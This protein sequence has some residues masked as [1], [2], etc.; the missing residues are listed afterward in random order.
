M[1]FLWPEFLLSPRAVHCPDETKSIKRAGL[2]G[3]LEHRI[4][5][6]Q[7]WG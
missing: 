5:N 7:H 3:K 1:P 2:C 6:R 4:A